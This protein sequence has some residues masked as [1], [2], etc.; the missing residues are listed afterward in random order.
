MRK[1][2]SIQINL[3]LGIPN[4]VFGLRFSGLA[5]I[6]AQFKV[7][8][9]LVLFA[10][11]APAGC[12]GSLTSFLASALCL[13]SIDSA[14]FWA[15]DWLLFLFLAALVPLGWIYNTSPRYNLWL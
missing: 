9:F 1:L 2:I 5:E 15:L 3:K 14:G 8:P 4:D 6:I 10:S 11:L 7:L 12:E 13:S